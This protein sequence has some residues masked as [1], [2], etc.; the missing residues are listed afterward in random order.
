[1]KINYYSEKFQLILFLTVFALAA[2]TRI[3]RME[4]YPFQ[5]DK[6]ELAFTLS[7][8][9]FIDKGKPYSWSIFD[10]PK[11]MEF[12]IINFGDSN[13]TI[14]SSFR[15]I[16]KP[17][18][19]HPPLISVIEGIWLKFLGYSF[20]EMVPSMYSRFPVL[21][22]TLS[23]LILIFKISKH[24]FG[25]YPSLVS[26][27]LLAFSPSFILIHR[28]LI[29]ENFYLYFLLLA[30]YL[31]LKKKSIIPIIGLTILAGLSKITGLITIPIISYFYLLQKQPKKFIV[32]FFSSLILF[33]CFYF[34]YA[35]I[36]DW[37]SFLLAIKN[38]SYRLIGWTNPAFIF[39]FPSFYS[40][41]IFYDFSYYLILFLG[42]FSLYKNKNNQF[43]YF[44]VFICLILIWIS[45]G[46]TTALG[47]YKLPLFTFLAI[48]SSSLFTKLK[49]INLMVISLLIITIINNLG[50]VRY[51]THPF[52]NSELLRIAVISPFLII[53][54]ILLVSKYKKIT[55]NQNTLNQIK[56]S[57]LSILLL[58]Y[59]INGI[60]FGS[61]YYE[62]LCKDKKCPMP[63]VT[64]SEL[65]SSIY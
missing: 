16:I 7:G 27:I 39:A 12:K 29:G 14:D 61:K 17:W 30:L 13:F 53:F 40:K 58:I 22:F 56:I 1:M 50:I 31:A 37:P 38:Q 9:S 5:N 8:L 60:Y 57:T 63:K 42:L 45:S 32:Y 41:I 20:P 64:L 49:N 25:F 26:F 24:F 36:V 4:Y 51:P 10:Y 34:L 44:T 33:T 46:E 19:D 3:W 54:L 21:L 65:I 23:S 15:T 35:Y 59:I 11:E 48:S 18:F 62:S 43:L 47:W 28:L 6:D 55:V 52:P 2:F